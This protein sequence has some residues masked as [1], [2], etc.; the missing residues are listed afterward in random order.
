MSKE[1]RVEGRAWRKQAPNGQKEGKSPYWKLRGKW[2]ERQYK[3]GVASVSEGVSATSHL[4][5]IQ[6]IRRKVFRYSGNG[7]IGCLG[8]AVLEEGEAET[9]YQ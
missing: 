4:F 9:G 3:A 2:P 1:Q 6:K 8:R 5:R 7:N